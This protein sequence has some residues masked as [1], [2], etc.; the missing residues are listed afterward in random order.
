MRGPTRICHDD[1]ASARRAAH[2]LQRARPVHA[3]TTEARDKS[4]SGTP[5]AEP[6]FEAAQYCQLTFT[7][8]TPDAGTV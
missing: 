1:G 2:L 6:I 8:P 5:S 4:T 7:L 3:A